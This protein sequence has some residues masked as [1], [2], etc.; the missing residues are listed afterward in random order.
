MGFRENKFSYDKPS[1]VFRIAFWGDSF[2]FGEGVKFEDTCPEKVVRPLNQKHDTR[3]R[4]FESYNFGVG[5]YNTAQELFLLKKIVLET[6]PDIV[7]LC[8]TLNDA[9]PARFQAIPL[10]GLLRKWRRENFIS[11]GMRGRK[12]PQSLWF[13]S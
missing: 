10:I 11:E 8:Y 6:H 13:K 3:G 5:G 2:T 9:E 1:G 7:I 4:L 12:P